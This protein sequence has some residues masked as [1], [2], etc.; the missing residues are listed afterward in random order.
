MKNSDYDD[1]GLLNLNTED[2][3]LTKSKLKLKKELKNKFAFKMTNNLNRRNMSLNC[4][5]FNFYSLSGSI[6]FIFISFLNLNSLKLFVL[7]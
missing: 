4:K 1:E 5:Y 7:D 6:E 2:Y 3:I